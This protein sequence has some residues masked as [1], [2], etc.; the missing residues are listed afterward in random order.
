M[1]QTGTTD[2]DKWVSV[3]DQKSCKFF[4]IRTSGPSVIMSSSLHCNGTG[5]QIVSHHRIQ[6]ITNHCVTHRWTPQNTRRIIPEGTNQFLYTLSCLF[7]RYYATL[8]IL[9]LLFTVVNWRP[10][11]II[12]SFRK[13]C[14]EL[15]MYNHV[16]HCFFNF[17]L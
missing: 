11:L 12:I 17:W 3:E 4:V 15:F 6:P 13:I 10:I 8:F 2:A 9:C 5:G 16:D 1:W 14:F 7:I